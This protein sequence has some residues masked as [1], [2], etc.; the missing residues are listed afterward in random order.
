M[1]GRREPQAGNQQLVFLAARN[2]ANVVG[3][4]KLVRGGDV[5]HKFPTVL[6]KVVRVTR[7]AHRDSQPRWLGRT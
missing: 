5:D 1:E 4:G 2:H 6:D 7:E 3:E